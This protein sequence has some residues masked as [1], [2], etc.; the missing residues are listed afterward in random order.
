MGDLRAMVK[1]FIGRED[2]FTWNNPFLKVQKKSKKRSNKHVPYTNEQFSLIKLKALERGEK[3]LYLFIHFIYYLGARPGQEIRL[4]QV[5]D[6]L[7]KTVFIPDD[8]AKNDKG[9]HIV[10]SKGLERLIQEYKLRSFPPHYYIFTTEGE[11][12]E[13]HVGKKYFY[14]RH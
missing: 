3:Q 5:K 12:G 9:E 8:R 10:I 2:G 4:L 13:E 14:R 7:K 11:P 6:I 1:F